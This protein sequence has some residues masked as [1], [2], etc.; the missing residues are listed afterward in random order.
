MQFSP[1]AG[2]QTVHQAIHYRSLTLGHYLTN[3]RPQDHQELGNKVT[4]I[5]QI[6]NV[7]L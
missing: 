4:N 5:L 2:F 3:T 6:L 1:F 7:A